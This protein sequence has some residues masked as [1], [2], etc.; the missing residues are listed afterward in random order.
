[1]TYLVISDLGTVMKARQLAQSGI[2]LQP[3]GGQFRRRDVAKKV[4]SRSSIVAAHGMCRLALWP[5]AA[6]VA[7]QPLAALARR[8]GFLR[9]GGPFASFAPASLTEAATSAQQR[10]L[11]LMRREPIDVPPPLASRDGVWSE[12]RE[13]PGGIAVNCR[14]GRRLD[15]FVYGRQVS[16][17]GLPS[18]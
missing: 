6:V 17:I 10:H 13:I 11:K 9:R 15:V 3:E 4:L 8:D 14:G 12:G 16:I 1:V 2:I 5:G 7:F 18:P